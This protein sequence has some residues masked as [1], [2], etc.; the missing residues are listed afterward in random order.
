MIPA[1]AFKDSGQADPITKTAD[2]PDKAF[3]IF[4]QHFFYKRYNFF[5]NHSQVYLSGLPDFW[6]SG[7]LISLQINLNRPIGCDVMKHRKMSDPKTD[8]DQAGSQKLKFLPTANLTV[9]SLS[10]YAHET[11][12]SLVHSAH[13]CLRTCV[14]FYCQWILFRIF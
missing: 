14:W 1:Y 9:F 6:E 10:F 5:L 4:Q 11:L 2:T 12:Q 8:C 13:R 3:L 7:V